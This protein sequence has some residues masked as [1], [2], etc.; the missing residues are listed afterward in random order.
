MVT[1]RTGTAKWK[2]IRTKA[3]RDALNNGQTQCP[4]CRTKLDWT[5]SLTPNS[6]E[7][8]HITPWAVGGADNADNT[9]II[10]RQCNQKLGGKL[11]GSRR[12]NRKKPI[13]QPAKPAVLLTS[14]PL[15]LI[16]I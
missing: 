3:I 1:S 2:H 16:H 15:S 5:R 6:P 4:I 14:Q 7:V 10:C 9:R 13:P 8:D 11:G 12:A